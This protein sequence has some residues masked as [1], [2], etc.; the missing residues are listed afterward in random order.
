MKRLS[1]I[2]LLLLPAWL[3]T[4]FYIVGG[5]EKAVVRRF[6]RVVSSGGTPHLR[7]SGWHYDLPWPF[8]RIDRVNTGEIR[9]VTV[10]AAQSVAAGDAEFLPE[11]D[12]SARSQFL[13]GDKNVLHLQISVQYRVSEAGAADYL[14]GSESPEDRLSR[15]VE[16]HTADLVSRSGVDFV[17]PIG[18]GELRLLLAERIER[19]AEEHRLGVIVED[20]TIDAV[21][22]PVQV[23]ADFLDV[24]NARADKQQYVNSAHA[25]AEQRVAAGQ[26][27]ARQILDEA[28]TYRQQ[29]VQ[30]ARGEAESFEKLIAQLRR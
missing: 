12:D 1:L 16:S 9:T 3:A 27:E 8:A 22:P 7:E 14:F 20:V 24:A 28:A 17:H 13:T 29:T 18:L 10:G 5:N 15:L 26:A 21:S 2:L 11:T 4:G 30:T 25:Y 6:G 19:S 23:K